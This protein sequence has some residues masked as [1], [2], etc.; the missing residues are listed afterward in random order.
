LKACQRDAPAGLRELGD[1][2]DATPPNRRELH[3]LENEG[4]IKVRYEKNH[5]HCASGA[6]QGQLIA[7]GLT[8]FRTTRNFAHRRPLTFQQ[9]R[10]QDNAGYHVVAGCSAQSDSRV[11]ARW[12]VLATAVN[13]RLPTALEWAPFAH[14]LN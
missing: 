14:A 5:A 1:K 13:D 11:V 8:R 9:Q 2:G 4:A 10:R 6:L 7:Q 12:R 3:E